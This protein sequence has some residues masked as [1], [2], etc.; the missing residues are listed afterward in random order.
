MLKNRLYI[1]FFIFWLVTGCGIINGYDHYVYENAFGRREL[2]EKK[3][4]KKFKPEMTLVANQVYYSYYENPQINYIMHQYLQLYKTGQYAY[5]VND[6]PL[7]YLDSAKAT[8]VGYYTFKD[9]A[10]KLE[11]GAGNFNTGSYRVI[12]DFKKIG[13]TLQRVHYTANT[14][15]EPTTTIKA[16]TKA[17]DW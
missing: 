9:N 1:V 11:T 4:K 16:D 15:Y 5:Y 14:V 8:H 6:K 2:K 7:D 12:W 17:P 13:A 3:F 10:L